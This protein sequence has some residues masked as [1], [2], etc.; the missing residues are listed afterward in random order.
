MAK[1]FFFKQ[2]DST[3]RENTHE[4]KKKGS[5]QVYP[6]VEVQTSILR[7]TKLG[8]DPRIDKVHQQSGVRLQATPFPLMQ[9]YI[10]AS[11]TERIC[12]AP[13]VGLSGNLNLAV[14]EQFG[15]R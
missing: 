15:T 7:Q 14:A 9:H 3:R 1:L 2:K 6:C 13:G 8:D 4:E 5:C 10:C 11:S 12:S